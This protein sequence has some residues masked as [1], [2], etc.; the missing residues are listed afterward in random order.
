MKRVALSLLA[1][2]LFLGCAVLVGAQ[3]ERVKKA[4]EQIPLEGRTTQD[5]VPKGWNVWSEAKGDLNGD[6][7]E[8]AALTLSLS[9]ED[10]EK[11]KAKGGDDFEWPPYIV[12]VL[13]AKREGGY[14]R[15]AVNGRLYPSVTGDGP[16]DLKIVK[17]VLITNQNYRDGWAVDATFRFRYDAALRKLMLIGFDLE[18][19]SRTSIYE[20]RKASENYLTGDRIDYAKS[21]GPRKQSSA[22]TVTKRS[23][24]ARVRKTFEE[25]RFNDAG[26][27][28]DIR[29]Y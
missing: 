26:D 7:L 27:L 21:N 24:I 17:G 23:R 9:S 13:F 2:S 11:M 6:G 29:P 5:F 20:G 10:I 16:L 25:A 28:F 18:N 19:Y 8:D 1:V 14:K 12:V 15:F 4:I 3:T 22:Y